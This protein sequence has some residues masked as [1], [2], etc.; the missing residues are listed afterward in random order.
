MHIFP[1]LC[2]NLF[3]ILDSI[4][5][6]ILLSPFS[7]DLASRLIVCLISYQYEYAFVARF[8]PDLLHPEI[9]IV[10][11]FLVCDAVCHKD[12]VSS[13]VV[14]SREGL[15]LLLAGRV[16]DLQLDESVLDLHWLESEFCTHCGC[17]LLLWIVIFYVSLFKT[18]F[19]HATVTHHDQLKHS[20]KLQ[21]G[22]FIRR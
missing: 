13:A 6:R 19:A 4:V 3:K 2:W 5:F 14:H 15:E 16:P 18:W 20:V 8:V 9:Q 21:R 11:T 22:A 10:E 17:C 12:R 7:F 1:V